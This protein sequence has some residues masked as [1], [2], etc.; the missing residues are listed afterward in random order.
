MIASRWK[1]ALVAVVA[2]LALLVAGGYLFLARPWSEY[3][4]LEMNSLFDADERVENFR[5]MDE[6]FPAEPIDAA[7]AR[8]ELPRDI[9]PLR[10]TYWFGGEQRTLDDFLVRVS[11]TGLLVIKDGTIVDERYLQGADAASRFTSWSMAKSFVSTLVGLALA[12]GRIESLDD[13][14]SDYVPELADSAYDGVPIRHVLQMSSGVDFDETYDS[15]FSDIN[16]FFIKLF[17]LGKSADDTIDDYDSAEPSGRR[18]HYAS[19]D[20][21][22]LGMLVRAVYR[23]PLVEVLEERLWHPLGAAAAS[24]NIDDTDGSGTAIAFCCLNARLRDFARLGQLYLQGG[25]WRG[26]RLL[27]EEWVRQATTPGAPFL[28]PGAIPDRY[29]RR[30]YQYQWWVPPGYHREYYAGG[31]WGQYVYVSE[32]DRLVIA[33]TSVDPDYRQ[34]GEESMAVFRAIADALRR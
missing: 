7:P 15:R 1:K 2:V 29:G 20:T 22:A 4:L 10:V 6:I 13:P 9:R 12:E 5:H 8:F 18:F 25:R 17:L 32:P 27:P 28:E 24:W 16:L 19:I 33:R 3:S 21:Q 30:G 31:I 14:I 11:A 34:H 23:R 26:Q